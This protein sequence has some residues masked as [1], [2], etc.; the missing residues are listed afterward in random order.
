MSRLRFAAPPQP[1]DFD[2]FPKGLSE[3]EHPPEALF[4]AGTWPTAR[5]AVAVV[6]TR[7]ADPEHRRFAHELAAELARAGVLV[8]SG[9]ALGIDAAAHRGALEA[10]GETVAVL[11]SG[12]V[13]AYPPEHAP[14]F[15]QIATQGAVVC[16]RED[17]TRAT[18]V[19]QAPARSGALSTAAIARQ[20][21]R[22]VLAVP[23]APWDRRSAGST[24][25]LTRG[26]LVCLGARQVLEVLDRPLPDPAKTKSAA[27]VARRTKAPTAKRAPATPSFEGDT[28]TLFAAL[29]ATPT[30]RDELVERSG[31][32]VPRMQR[33]LLELVLAG[34]ANEHP[35]GRV[36]RVG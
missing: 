18:V 30:H 35:D 13:Q 33:A 6:G 31:L 25:L 1:L 12:L 29:T 11:A 23:S 19:V 4:V 21:G 24:A 5:P 8:V 36:V 9:G 20:L 32:D 15:E 17:T 16:E 3:L 10:G 27:K 22:W 7:A 2:R 26:A 34:A 28:A 14:L